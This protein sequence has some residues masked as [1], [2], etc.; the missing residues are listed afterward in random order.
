MATEALDIGATGA[1]QCDVMFCAPLH[2]LEEI[3][4]VCLASQAAVSGQEPG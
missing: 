4:L 2:V 3:Q 1:E